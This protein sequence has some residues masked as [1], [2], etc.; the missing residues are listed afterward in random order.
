MLLFGKGEWE[1]SRPC[2][3]M[4]RSITVRQCIINYANNHAKGGFSHAL[5]MRRVCSFRHRRAVNT[6]ET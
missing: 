6:D 1:G 2:I 4:P 5:N 3:C